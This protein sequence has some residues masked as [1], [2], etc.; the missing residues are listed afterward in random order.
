MQWVNTGGEG[1]EDGRK[2]I[3]ESER[4]CV[5]VGGAESQNVMSRCS[6]L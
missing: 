1:I 6:Q 2:L 4:V 5:C 3:K